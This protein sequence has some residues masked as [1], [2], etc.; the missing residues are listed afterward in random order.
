MT[1]DSIMRSVRSLILLTCLASMSSLWGCASNWVSTGGPDSPTGGLSIELLMEGKAQQMVRLQLSGD[2]LLKYAGGRD[3]A[4]NVYSWEGRVDRADGQAVAAAVRSGQ[5]F[6]DP[7][8]GDG[9]ETHT[10]WIKAW[11]AQGRHANFTVYGDAKS[12]QT[13]YDILNKIASSRFSSY[14]D[15]LPEPSLDRQL[16]RESAVEN[17]SPSGDP[18]SKDSNE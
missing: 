6:V 2:G 16:K 13:V 10:W 15:A 11:D 18:G 17:A 1:T 9:N 8:S 5:W 3:V 7:P 14:L 4:N 12:V